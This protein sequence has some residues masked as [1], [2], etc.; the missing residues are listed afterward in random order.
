M[1]KKLTE[2]SKFKDEYDICIIGSG[3]AGAIAAHELGKSGK[4]VVV[5]EAGS[6]QRHYDDSDEMFNEATRMLHPSLKM[7]IRERDEFERDRDRST[8]DGQMF[9][10]LGSMRFKTLGGSSHVWGGNSGRYTPSD[11]RLNS[12]HGVSVDWP[13]TYD[14]LEEHYYKAEMEMGV[15]TL[16]DNPYIPRKRETGYKLFP[17]SYSASIWLEKLKDYDDINL[18]YFSGNH[19]T[20]E[21]IEGRSAC[22]N[23]RVCQ[24]CPI[25][26]F[27]TADV[28]I[29][30][31]LGTGNVDFILDAN[32]S[33]LVEQDGKI[34]ELLVK[35][36]NFNEHKVSADYFVLAAGGVENAR[37]LL[38]SSNNKNPD[39]LSNRSGAVGRYFMEH[40]SFDATGQ[41]KEVTHAKST[42]WDHLTLASSQFVN[43]ANRDKATGF[44]MQFGGSGR[45]YIYVAFRDAGWGDLNK[46]H[47]VKNWEKYNNRLQIKFTFDMLPYADNRVGLDPYVKNVFGEPV[48]KVT[49]HGAREY[50]NNGVALAH[51]ISKKLFGRIGAKNLDLPRA[52]KARRHHIGTTRM[53]NN[54]D[55]S[56]VDR[57]GKSHEIDNLYII[58]SSVHPTAGC[59]GV[60]LTLVATTYLTMS[61]MISRI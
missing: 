51:K 57:N 17:H 55:T 38:L 52:G 61:H 49:F 26:A 56:V 31:A 4:K 39:G 47:L 35:D 34:S 24:A 27:Y 10:P 44:E 43:H 37:L 41:I 5:L 22:E 1:I 18:H 2:I 42:S 59:S 29:Q 45:N 20:A 14:D 46:E 25:G 40:L 30:K 50:E 16:D 32:V 60:T 3:F 13:I 53:G 36:R 7:N 6:K 54:P 11:F 33:K 23:F 28:H 58:G 15:S 8:W 48:P 19:R 21:S 12:E 9:Y